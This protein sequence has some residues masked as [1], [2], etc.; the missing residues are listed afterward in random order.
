MD[1]LLK[2]AGISKALFAEVVGV[3]WVMVW[4]W[5]NTPPTRGFN[6]ERGKRAHRLAQM[7]MYA[8]EQGLLSSNGK[9]TK[10]G[11]VAALKQAATLRS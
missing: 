11:L 8:T 7:I 1:E 5:C 4:H 3:S 10:A 2:R 6:G 9:V